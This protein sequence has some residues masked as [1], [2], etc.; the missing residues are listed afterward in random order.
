MGDAYSCNSGSSG[1]PSDA[2][3]GGMEASFTSGVRLTAGDLIEVRVMA[4]QASS[5]EDIGISAFTLDLI[6]DEGFPY[7]L[8]NSDGWVVYDED[9]DNEEITIGIDP[10]IA[11]ACPGDL[12]LTSGYDGTPICTRLLDDAGMVS[13]AFELPFDVGSVTLDIEYNQFC[14]CPMI[15][16]LSVC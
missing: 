3:Y 15:L 13:A 10:S 12:V 9:S 5:N 14:E 1:S 4:D 6:G 2:W 8:E 11:G 16:G 7:V